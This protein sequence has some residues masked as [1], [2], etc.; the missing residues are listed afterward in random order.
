[1]AKKKKKVNQWAGKQRDASLDGMFRTL[2]E[3]GQR[4]LGRSVSV[5]SDLDT[6]FVGLPLPA[7]CLRYLFQV[8]T[9]PLSR[10]IQLA[11]E[12]GT[13][14]SSF[15][16]E[17][18]RWH[19]MCGGG[20]VLAENENKDAPELR[21]AIMQHREEWIKR[22]LVVPTYT[23][24]Q[25]QDVF[26]KYIMLARKVQDAKDG[27]G[28]TVPMMFAVDSIMS[29]APQ[30]EIDAVIKEGHAKRGHALA[31]N[32]IARYMRTI[33]KLIEFYP[34]T[35]A[36][37]NHLKPATTPQGLPTNNIPGGKAVKFM[38]TFEIEMKK[39]HT[40]YN[41][42]K[43]DYSGLRVVFKIKKNAR[44][45]GNKNI[46][47][48]FLW[49]FVKNPDTDKL[50]Q[51]AMWDWHT[52]TL[53]MYFGF[54]V[55]DG[56]KTLFKKLEEITGIKM[57]GAKGQRK[58]YSDILGI[59]EDNAQDW[60]VVAAALE[61]R[62]DILKDVHDVLGIMERNVFTPAVDYQEQMR[63]AEQQNTERQREAFE[64]AEVIVQGNEEEDGQQ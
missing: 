21:E 16:Y 62:P 60:R 51:H 23:M 1:M 24:E 22:T 11:G 5:G 57:A 3:H 54:S 15:L 14:K 44:G 30:E 19:A 35:V 39:A 43:A 6:N 61:A 32:L 40:G 58:A 49:W 56:K 2:A 26:T 28:R 45:P 25:W 8:T 12:E 36:G 42:E 55:Q 18:M 31:A 64:N 53:D 4:D 52:A 41:I 33:P 38:E 7:L 10:I 20:S 27:P 48:E 50:V 47:A 37:T 13:A 59:S 17:I 46:T 9:Y 63:T 29:T 34:F